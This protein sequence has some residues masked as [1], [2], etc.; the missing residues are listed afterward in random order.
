L[1]LKG[2][3]NNLNKGELM[4]AR[5]SNYVRVICVAIGATFLATLLFAGMYILRRTLPVPA[6]QDPADNPVYSQYDFSC[7][8]K[9]VRI[10]V[11]P[12]YAPT[13]LI[14]ETMRRDNILRQALSKTGTDICFY[15]FFNGDDVNYFLGRGDLDG[16]IGGDMPAITAAANLDV[17]IPAM[18]QQG[19]LSIVAK[20]HMFIKDL[21]KKRL[22]YAYGSNAHY[23]LLSTLASEGLDERHVTLIPLD[24]TQ[25]PEALNRGSIDAFSA[26]EPT[27]TISLEKFKGSVVIHQVHSTGYIYFSLSFAEAHRATVREIIAA[28]I[29]A[30]KWLTQSNQNLMTAAEWVLKAEESLSGKSP[31]LTPKQIAELAR[32]DILRAYQPPYVPS[33][34]IEEN[35]P[36]HK[37]FSFLLSIGKIN[38]NT[39]WKRVRD[40]FNRTIVEDVINDSSQYRLDKVEYY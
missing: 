11:Q 22:G 33:R 5:R 26:W 37:E 14:T 15:P 39:E 36:L 16:G 6:K 25:M 13:G 40:S 10:G 23:A 21:R 2:I 1:K 24:V 4:D 34:Q 17:V 28:E 8:S 18:V 12:L 3:L 29:R 38:Q 20:R 19:Y 27:P 32:K 9:A 7:A 35:G 31:L 30:V